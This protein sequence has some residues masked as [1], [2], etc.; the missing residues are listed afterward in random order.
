[1]TNFTI[2]D[3]DGHEPKGHFTIDNTGRIYR[4]YPDGRWFPCP[5]Y[6]IKEDES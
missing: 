2:C 1:M 5:D 4:L 3:S 6:R